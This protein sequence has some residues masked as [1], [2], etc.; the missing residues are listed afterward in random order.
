M[1]STQD[2]SPPAKRLKREH[3]TPSPLPSPRRTPS[4]DLTA[5]KP[6]PIP[7]PRKTTGIGAASATAHTPPPSPGDE[8]I[9][10]KIDLSGI[11]DDVVV[12]C[13]E[14]LEKT[15]NRPHL[16]KELATVLMTTNR[17]IA[18]SANPA[19]LLSSRLTTY[20]KRDW[21]ALS[22]CPIA[23]ELVPVHPRKVFFFLT[24]RPRGELPANSDDIIAPAISDIKRLT[25]S[26]TDPSVEDEEALERHERM[27]FS[28]SP[29]VELF[30]PE[31]SS[32]KPIPAIPTIPVTP[33]SS[34]SGRSLHEEPIEPPRRQRPS[35]RAPSPTLEADERGFTETASAVRAS[36]LSQQASDLQI[37]VQQPEEPRYQAEHEVASSLFGKL[38]GTLSTSINDKHHLM[39]SPMM[40][41][42]HNLSLHIRD[43]D[44][45]LDEPAWNIKSPEAISFDE[46]DQ[47]F[48]DL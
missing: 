23:K 10:R 46:L 17:N 39:S 18:N 9:Y 21:T 41:P 43:I 7:Q 19:A 31:L 8:V 24:S 3:G 34:Y 28:P 45:D 12:S 32:S 1:T 22:P 42:K 13:I 29:E 5:S 36:R 26:I 20:M 11:S 48:D 15:A 30:S 44:M 6:Q 27:Q 35:N 25:P 14:Q 38:S 4:T 47:M 16:L 2:H 37:N 33:G 40:I